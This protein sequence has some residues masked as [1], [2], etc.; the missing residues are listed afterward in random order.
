VVVF[1]SP[2][3]AATIGSAG[4]ELW[5]GGRDPIRLRARNLINAAGLGAQSLAGA[6]EGLPPAVVPP[7]RLA[8][9]NYYGLSGRN[10]FRRL[11]YPL[12]EPGGLGVH[13]TIDMGGQARFGP[14]VE[15]I[16]QKTY[17][18]DPGRADCFYAAVRRYWPA[19][20]DGALV[21]A[22]AGIRPKLVGPG[23]DDSDFVIQGP[24]DHGI[25]GL[26]NLFGIES[27]GLTSCMAIAAEVMEKL[28]Q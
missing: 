1:R 14:D 9:G 13:V 15:W 2:V 11:V 5:V 24:G 17:N 16:E 25:P 26:V 23:G 12:P 21:P 7:L 4:I 18:V 28:R 10:P 6:M 22:Y 27:P 19:L 8:K 3:Q 20:P